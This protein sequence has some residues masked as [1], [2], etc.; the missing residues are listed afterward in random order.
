[1]GRAGQNELPRVGD[2]VGGKYR[3]RRVIGKGGMAVVL[4]ADH[5]LLNNVVALKVLHPELVS[6]VACASRFALEA[7]A[8]ARLKSEHAVRIL[9]VGRLDQGVPYMVMEHLE[10]CSIAEILD[11]RGSVSFAE[12]VP[13]IIQACDAIGEAHERGI[14]HRDVKPGNLFLARNARGESFVKVLDFGLV[15]T[16]LGPKLHITVD[17]A[18]GGLPPL[19]GSPH[20]MSPEQIACSTRVDARTDVWSLG[21][22]LYELVTGQPAF[23]AADVRLLFALV[24]R[25][26]RPTPVREL[27]PDVP[28]A[29]EAV[30]MRC[31]ERDPARRFP[32]AR[33]LGSALAQ[34]MPSLAV[35]TPGPITI[36]ALTRPQ[37][38]PTGVPAFVLAI[39]AMSMLMLWGV[40]ARESA[41]QHVPATPA[42]YVREAPRTLET[43]GASVIVKSSGASE[44]APARPRNGRRAAR[45]PM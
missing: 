29:I 30:I 38:E 37:P 12:A 40:V 44:R 25:G 24:L 3:I 5:L 22:T 28:P 7:Q 9:D 15:K 36:S 6:D 1:M 32:N 33:A 10:G 20:Y 19:L 14:V 41:A 13:W 4:A 31:L 35:N 18:K 34:A 27:R 42:T 16:I 11:K 23:D 43:S 2:V 17:Q 8:A 45:A 21:A 26:G 39:V